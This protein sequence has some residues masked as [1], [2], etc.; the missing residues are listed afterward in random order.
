[1]DKLGYRITTLG[2]SSDSAAMSAAKYSIDTSLF[3]SLVDKVNESSSCSDPATNSATTA[4]STRSMKQR[5]V[6]FDDGS[7]ED[8]EFLAD[9]LGRRLTED[10]GEVIFEVGQEADGT[11]MDLTDN[12][13]AQVTA[14]L[15]K[16]VQMPQVASFVQLLVDT[17]A[18]VV[19]QSERT[20]AREFA[21]SSSAQS[22][23]A[24]ATATKPKGVG[25]GRSANATE[26][27]KPP[28]APSVSSLVRGR[29]AYYLI[30]RK[31]QGVEQ[32]LEVRVAVAGNVDAGKS[33][34]LGVLTQGR[35]DDGRGKARVALFRHQHEIESGRTSSVSLEI[36]GFDKTTGAPVRHT[37]PSRKVSWDVVCSRSSKLVSFLDLAGHEKYLKTTVFGMA[38]GAPDYVMLMVAANA[39]LNGMAKEHLGLALALGIPVFVVITKIDMCPPNVLD[40]TIKQLT[41]VLRS[42]GCRKLPIAVRDRNSVIMAASR[43]V[44]QR[45]CPIFQISNVTGEGIDSLQTFLNVLP[46]NRCYNAPTSAPTQAN[47][48]ITAAKGKRTAGPAAGE[49]QAK[50]QFDISEVFVVPFVGTIV[51]GVVISGTL[52]PGDPVWLGPDYNGHFLQTAVR[53]IQRKRVDAQAAYTGQSV[54]LWLKKVTRLQVRKGMVLLGRSE[55]SS[56]EPSSSKTFEAEVVVLYHS[57]TI[58]SRY[59]AMIH[60]GSVRQTARILSIEQADG[61]AET[62]RTGDRARVV[63]QFIRH[64]EYLTEGTRLIFREGRTKG[65]GKVLRV[66]SK[67]EEFEAVSKATKGTMVF[68][69]RSLKVL[70]EG[71]RHRAASAA[72]AANAAAAASAKTDTAATAAKNTLKHPLKG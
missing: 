14:T 34:M 42:S 6:Q 27:D 2:I 5:L 50:M 35:L 18:P 13:I 10:R 15:T 32:I 38:G 11:S 55:H 49:V 65:V 56:E 43:F 40:S 30:R 69:H 24:S 28:S 29:T 7:N 33:T 39:G 22:A 25:Q 21:E 26:Q 12:D 31:P 19:V 62:L 37:D 63:F 64:P 47:T 60:C 70:N 52:K 3:D 66:L 44:S 45:V 8:A 68:D 1:M 61:S 53:T 54:S 67:A 46:L 51:S 20:F 4:A 9:L 36:L 23:S 16:V 72:N 59:Q 57:T 17:G 58:S 71:I 41:K 48:D